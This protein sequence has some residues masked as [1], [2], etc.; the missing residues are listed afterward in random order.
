MTAKP[1]LTSDLSETKFQINPYA[2]LFK[3]SFKGH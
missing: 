1:S 3:L 2:H